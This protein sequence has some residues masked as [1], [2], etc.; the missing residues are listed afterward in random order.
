[1]EDTTIQLILVICCAA[2]TLSLLS[3]IWSYLTK[4]ENLQDAMLKE[5]A[6]RYTLPLADVEYVY[7]QCR[8]YDRTIDI[9]D[10]R[11]EYN[12][13]VDSAINLLR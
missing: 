11:N 13:S 8:S 6:S 7:D 10:Y 12:L 2:A 5:I 3:H 4:P 1:M 9:L